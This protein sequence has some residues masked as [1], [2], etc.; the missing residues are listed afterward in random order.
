MSTPV[1]TR[2]S[3]VTDRT[4]IGF[5]GSRDHRWTKPIFYRAASTSRCPGWRL[6]LRVGRAEVDDPGFSRAS[7]Q[8]G[9]TARR[10]RLTHHDVFAVYA[11]SPCLY[12]SWAGELLRPTWIAVSIWASDQQYRFAAAQGNGPDIGNVLHVAVAIAVRVAH[13]GH[14][15]PLTVRRP[16]RRDRPLVMCQL[17][18]A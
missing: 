18:Q 9:T 1:R 4:P 3:A 13:L 15:D 7:L 14:G 10:P 8:T 2:W 11:R 17:A 16:G 12:A 6:A 5:A